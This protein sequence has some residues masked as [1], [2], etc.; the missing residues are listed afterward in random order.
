MEK[1]G[2]RTRRP[3]KIPVRRI[4]GDRPPTPPVEPQPDLDRLLRWPGRPA[5]L[6]QIERRPRSR[7]LPLVLLGLGVV[8]LATAVG[9]AVFTRSQGKFSEAQVQLSFDL[10]AT[11]ASGR[12]LPVVVSYLNNQGVALK[13]SELTLEYPEG[14]SVVSVE[15][16]SSGTLKNSWSLGTVKAGFGGQVA[17]RGILVGTLESEKT[18]RATLTYRPANFNSDFTTQ[19]EATTRITA[20]SVSLAVQG[21]SRA[22][23]EKAT[24]LTLRVEN[25]SAEALQG[26]KLILDEAEG[27][28][29]VTAEPKDDRQ[30]WLIERL[31]SQEERTIS[32]TGTFSGQTGEQRQLSFRIGFADGDGAFTPQATATLEV[33]IVN[34]ELTLTATVSGPTDGVV[35][36]GETITYEVELKNNTDETVEDLTVT[37]E[38][39]PTLVDWK[40]ATTQ[41]AANLTAATQDGKVTWSTATTKSLAKLA[42]TGSLSFT[43]TAPVVAA[44]T[45]PSAKAKN[46]TLEARWKAVS[47]RVES[48]G[49][50]FEATADPLVIKIGTTA[51]LITEARY[52]AEEGNPLGSGPLPPVVGQTTSYRVSWILSN[53]TNDL[54]EVTV[55]T[56]LPGTTFWTGKVQSASAGSLSFDPGSRTVSWTLNRVPAGVGTLTSQLSASFEL[57][58]T[59]KASDVGLL[60]VLTDATKLTGTD[61]FTKTSLTLEPPSLTTELANDLPARG[62]GI[63]VSVE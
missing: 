16:S 37:A 12:E 15:P 55:R 19:A 34:P 51:K 36:L 13:S 53:L 58:V 46:L 47:R 7:L 54:T 38:L 50:P 24:S 8:A 14:F 23:A 62:K 40:R 25:T 1:R 43:L 4:S 41:P 61:D 49:R 35:R 27:F 10:S 28:S 59:P 42:P 3:I 5:N 29:L 2:G 17:I 21:P 11:A 30:T 48:F 57:S 32:L 22:V 56:T 31:G 20:S 45:E 60:M 63:V 6:R 26:L 33:E 44:T 9:F 52:Y 39:S 18:F